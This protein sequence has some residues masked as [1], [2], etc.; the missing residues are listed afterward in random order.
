MPDRC[1]DGGGPWT[2]VAAAL[3]SATS[4]SLPRLS[5]ARFA[6]LETESVACG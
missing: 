3:R 2:E 4:A 1:S 5:E 6:L